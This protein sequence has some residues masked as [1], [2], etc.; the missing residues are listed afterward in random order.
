[1]VWTRVYTASKDLWQ[2]GNELVVEGKVRLRDDRVQLNCD[3]VRLYQPEVTRSEEVITPEPDEAPVL[4]EEPPPVATLPK[5]HRLVIS[6]TQTSDE[7]N[8]IA[9]L[10]KVSETLKEFPGD[11]DVSLCVNAEERVFN[12]KLPNTGY[13]P[14][15]HQRLV[16]LVG[17]GGVR[18]ESC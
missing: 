6:I 1:M 18:V 17:E 16:E 9:N 14:E 15:L 13:C 11:D 10:R 8:D 7:E 3:R 5:S 12:V 2:E 4:A